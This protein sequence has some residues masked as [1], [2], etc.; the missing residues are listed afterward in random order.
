MIVLE[1]L[2]LNIFFPG[3][4]FWSQ[5][6]NKCIDLYLMIW[7]HNPFWSHCGKNVM[8]MLEIEKNIIMD[9][10]FSS[11]SYHFVIKTTKQGELNGILLL[12]RPLHFYQN[13]MKMCQCIWYL[14]FGPL[15]LKIAT[16][17]NQQWRIS[18]GDSDVFSFGISGLIKCHSGNLVNANMLM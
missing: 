10:T 8:K 13:G 11:Q 12:Y 15:H 4:T 18:F 1:F 3:S 16:P 6:Y 17:K 9:N 2:L 7:V 14:F 5:F